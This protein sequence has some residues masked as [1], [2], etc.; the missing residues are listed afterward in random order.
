MGCRSPIFG[1][2]EI[3]PARLD[4]II[5]E[6]G[7]LG[8]SDHLELRTLEHRAL[9]RDRTLLVLCRKARLEQVALRGRNL[10]RAEARRPQAAL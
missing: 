9:L 5:P 2:R 4:V 10:I 3:P 1:R 8:L 6:F 7:E